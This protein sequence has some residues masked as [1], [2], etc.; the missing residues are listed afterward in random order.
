MKEFSK[1]SNVVI[2]YSKANSETT[3]EKSSEKWF[4]F[5]AIRLLKSVYCIWQIIGCLKLQVIFRQRA[6]DYRA[7]L[8]KMTMKIRHPMT[9]R[10][11]VIA[12]WV[13]SLANSELTSEN[14]CL[15]SAATIKDNK[16]KILK[17]QLAIRF[18]TYDRYGVLDKMI[19]LFCKRAL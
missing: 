8:R 6:T 7:L 17:S 3:S 15:A 11:P 2:T 5:W 1:V 19:G 9:L 10:H 13:K 4:D 16:E 12:S 18:S 14:L